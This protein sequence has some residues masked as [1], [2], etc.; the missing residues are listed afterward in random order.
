MCNKNREKLE[1]FSG[2]TKDVVYLEFKKEQKCVQEIEH[3][4]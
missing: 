2:S 4:K 3:K 1:K